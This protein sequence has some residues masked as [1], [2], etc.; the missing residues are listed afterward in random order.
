M[1]LINSEKTLAVAAAMAGMDEKTARKYR[2]AG[3]CPSQLA[4]PHAWRTRPDSFDEVW[5]QVQEQLQTNPGLEAKSL[6]EWFQ[7][8]T[9]GRFADGQLR[10]FQRRVKHW[11]ATQGPPREVMFPQR[12]LPGRLSQS[13]FTHLDAL[14]VTI[15][16]EPFPHLIYH[17][18]LTYS[19]WEAA[20]ICYS[21]N[22]E[23]L[24]EGLQNALWE[25][26]GVPAVH[27]TDNLSAALKLE[28]PEIFTTRWK[29]LLAHYRLEGAHTQPASPNENGDIE[30]RHHRFQRALE[31]SLL[32]RGGRDFATLADYD[33]FLRAL[34]AQ[35]NAGRAARFQEELPLLGRLPP[36]RLDDWQRQD[37][38]VGPH[39]TISLQGN[40]Y[41]VHSR[42]IG[43]RVQARLRPDTVEVWYGGACVETLARLRGRGRH[44]VNYRHV[45]DWLVR[46]PGA[47]E[48]YLYRED[49]FPT[50]RFRVAYDT[51]VAADPAKGH[52]HYLAILHLAATENETAVDECL[53]GLID[54]Q[55]PITKDAVA[56]AVRTQPTPAPPRQSR[57]AAVDLAQYDALCPDWAPAGAGEVAAC[58]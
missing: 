12:H 43:E 23:S 20:T 53:R 55:E 27:Q 46:K 56:A 40:A 45:I 5:P 2:D 34:L 18:V 57:V 58:R 24:A 54:R 17:F 44:G 8:Q 31:Q 19:N 6:F 14:G 48:R 25:L 30:Q 29:A 35:L 16:G 13:D 4:Q 39:S 42:L 21:E 49:L 10:T 33:K 3:L 28:T 37:A 22:F 41:S 38:V 9:P 50:S 26:G 32:L 36:R 51:L 47:F 52:K 15:A 1:K 7:R 11:R